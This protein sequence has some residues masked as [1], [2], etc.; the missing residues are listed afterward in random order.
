MKKY[1]KAEWQNI[2]ITMIL[3]MGFIILQSFTTSIV[4]IFWQEI[5]F[6]IAVMLWL[7]V[8]KHKYWIRYTV[9]L[10]LHVTIMLISR[11]SDIP[12]QSIL[13]AYWVSLGICG[14][15]VTMLVIVTK[16]AN[17]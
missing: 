16:I 14:V 10:V 9:V 2:V 13:L 4:R 12:E 17:R 11:S 1:T 6:F 5:A 8:I 3:L 7:R 15:L